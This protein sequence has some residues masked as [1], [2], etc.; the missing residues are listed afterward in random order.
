MSTSISY[1]IPAYNC[2]DTLEASVQS[3][4]NG[5][6]YP[7]DEVVIID[8]A[9]TDDT[10]AVIRA[11]GQQYPGI[12]T[13]RHRYNKGSAAAGR[14]TGI[15]IARNELLFCLDADNLLV[16]ESVPRLKGFLL[17]HQADAAAFQEKRFFM[18]QP[19]QTE[20]KW[21]YNEGVI[22]L[23]DAIAGHYWPGPSGNYL[24][25]RQSWIKAKRQNEFVGAGIDSWA[26]G[27]AQ[28]ISGAKMVVMPDSGYWHRF[29]HESAFSRENAAG[30][31]CLN[32]LQ[33]LLPFY[34]LFEPADFERLLDAE[35]RTVW[36]HKMHFGPLLR[37]KGMPYG[38]T[39]KA[40]YH[41]EKFRLTGP[42]PAKQAGIRSWVSET[43]NGIRKYK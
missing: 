37:L 2:Q 26:F 12:T 43:L 36:Y 9:S 35:Y 24:F 34:Q 19:G 30:R 22:S 11:I 5:N 8:D 42:G 40:I 29:G 4:Y 32:A 33:F 27:V 10:P 3:V 16:P 1:I 28:L 21:V 6:F 20:F 25:T 39:G 18:E 14:N 38:Q 31:I 41:N 15:D 13:C 17:S 7:G 23:N